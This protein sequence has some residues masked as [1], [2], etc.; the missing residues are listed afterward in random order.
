[1]FSQ[2]F[3]TTM[4]VIVY[5]SKS[6][7][8]RKYAEILSSRTGIPMYQLDD[9]P[10]G[11]SIVFFGWLRSDVVVGIDRVDRSRLV[12]VGVVGL[13]DVG[14]FQKSAVADRN[15]IKAPI[16]YMRG[17]IDRRRLGILDK[18]VLLAVSV[19]MKL[20]GLN[21]HNKPVFDAMMEGGS[22]FDEGYLDPMER[23]LT[24]GR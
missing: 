2:F 3:F 21:E 24:S 22:F 18:G 7:S 6:G 13:D 14:R 9:Q 11:E 10:E 16:Y 4:T 1:M 20:K 17:W 15:G 19:M 5:S 12:A 23:F 8:S